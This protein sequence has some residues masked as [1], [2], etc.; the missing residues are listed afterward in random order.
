M[1]KLQQNKKNTILISVFLVRNL[2]LLMTEMDL[3][4]VFPFITVCGLVSVLN[5]KFNI[6]KVGFKR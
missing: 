4:F 6:T 3:V 5:M 2:P 1:V